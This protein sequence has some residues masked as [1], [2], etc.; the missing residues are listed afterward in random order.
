MTFL[1]LG[2]TSPLKT[3]L[4]I[5]TH[6]I[7]VM[8]NLKYRTWVH[9]SPFRHECLTCF[10][11]W[12]CSHTQKHTIISAELACYQIIPVSPSV[13]LVIVSV[14]LST[15]RHRIPNMFKFHFGRYQNNLVLGQ[16]MTTSDIIIHT[17]MHDNLLKENTS[18]KNLHFL[19]ISRNVPIHYNYYSFQLKWTLW[20]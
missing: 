5:P 7:L 20:Q 2:R 19:H 16:T 9:L 6:N 10:F 15:V 4:R 12:G 13:P 17:S 14:N 3:I 1:I 8:T 18:W 11:H